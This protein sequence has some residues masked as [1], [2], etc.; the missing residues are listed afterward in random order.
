[1]TKL[2]ALNQA[3]QCAYIECPA[4]VVDDLKRRFDEY[5]AEQLAARDTMTVKILE[6]AQLTND[7]EDG[8]TVF[9][10]DEEEWGVIVGLARSAAR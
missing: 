10:P 1:V 4:H 9:M 2:D 7:T 8:G 6:V 3:F 5:L